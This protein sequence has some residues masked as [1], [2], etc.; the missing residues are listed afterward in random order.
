MVPLDACQLPSKEITV[1]G[2]WV[3][4]E[5]PGSVNGLSAAGAAEAKPGNR[6]PAFCA[7]NCGFW[8]AN[9][10]AACVVH[11]ESQYSACF[12][13]WHEVSGR[14]ISAVRVAA[15]CRNRHT[16]QLDKQEDGQ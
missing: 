16:S 3:G 12:N 13:F 14:A 1:E 11:F 9:P 5:S 8:V 10:S 15:Q 4:W 2:S 6:L 7:P